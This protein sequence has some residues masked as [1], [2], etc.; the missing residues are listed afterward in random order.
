MWFKILC[1][2]A[3]IC[4]FDGDWP[5]IICKGDL[6]ATRKISRDYPIRDYLLH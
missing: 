4:L 2:H 5:Q 3:F 1:P 6:K